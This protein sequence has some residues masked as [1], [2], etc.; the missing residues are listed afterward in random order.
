M[1]LMITSSR[2]T[3]VRETRALILNEV[4]ILSRMD[5]VSINQCLQYNINDM[6]EA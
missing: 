1:T 2:L 4:T 6:L 5:V 3:R